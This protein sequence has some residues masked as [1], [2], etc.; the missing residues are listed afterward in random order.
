MNNGINYIDLFSGIG[1]FAK[2][3]ENAGIKI[4]NHYYS[5]IDEHC[6]E[7]YKKH[8]PKA[9]ALGD[10]KTITSETIKKE[11]II[12][13]NDNNNINND[14]NNSKQQIDLITFGFPCQDLSVAGKRTG[15]D[16]SRSGLFF[17]AIRLI[18]EIKPACFIFENV[19]GLITNNGGKD[20]VRCLQEIGNIGL[21][22]CEWQLVNTR[23]FLPQN[24]ERIYFIGHSREKSRFKVF[25]IRESDYETS[26]IQRQQGSSSTSTNTI[27]TRTG[28]AR[29]RGT[30][31]IESQFYGETKRNLQGN[32][33]NTANGNSV[34]L[35]SNSGGQGAK[36]G[37]YAIPVITP[38]RLN[39][40]Q[41][42]RRFK[43]N[44]E[45]SFTLTSQDQHG[46]CIIKNDNKNNNN[47]NNT[48]S[49][50]I[51]RLTPLECE[52][53]QGFP[54][55]WTKTDKNGNEIKDTNRYRM[56]GNAVTVKVV[57]EIIKRL[58]N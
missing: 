42:G 44:G 35:S 26:F 34:C 7:I 56:L 19:K 24:R 12:D 32:R 50:S 57:E 55:N 48:N 17:E 23:W 16:G 11:P 36:T 13:N 30:Y 33:I 41:N 20:F 38:N 15:L 39:K 58:F 9:K 29:S 53:L 43:T 4:K 45:P 51:R 10:I 37:L 27:T 54:D 31:V 1:G 18:K 40:R 47:R 28:N 49:V 25:P 2:G 14:V 22:D 46:V 5:E 6:I 52:R 3:I 8:F 21:Y